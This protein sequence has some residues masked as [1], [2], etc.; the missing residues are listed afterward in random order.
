MTTSLVV[1]IS[2]IATLPLVSILLTKV[3]ESMLSQYAGW[4]PCDIPIIN[5]VKIA[6]T[7]IIAYAVIAFMQYQRVKKIPLDVALKN[8][9]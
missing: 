7:G 9:E 8:V 5:Y 2:L 3:F 6:V 1:I 4:I